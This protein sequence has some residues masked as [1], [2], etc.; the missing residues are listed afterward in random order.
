MMEKGVVTKITLFLNVLIL[1][2]SVISWKHTQENKPSLKRYAPYITIEGEPLLDSE[3]Y[4]KYNKYYK[5]CICLKKKK[6]YGKCRYCLGKKLIAHFLVR[7]LLP[8][9]PTAKIYSSNYTKIASVKQEKR[10]LMLILYHR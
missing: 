4:I 10:N 3:L 9:T 7:K 8:D 6:E 1:I 5:I 2:I